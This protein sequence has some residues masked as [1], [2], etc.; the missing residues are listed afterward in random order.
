MIFIEKN[1]GEGRKDPSKFTSINL[2]GLRRIL[3]IYFIP[4]E[5]S[6]KQHQL[7]VLA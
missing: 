4:E 2:R 1:P 3:R 6:S 5:Q 7:S